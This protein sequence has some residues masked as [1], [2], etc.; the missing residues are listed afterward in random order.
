MSGP[1]AEEIQA[2]YIV[3]QKTE[4]WC[5]NLERLMRRE[6][7]TQSAF[8]KKI[9]ARFFG[10]EER[11]SQKT[12]SNWMNVGRPDRQ[13]HV[14][15]FPKYEIMLQIADVLEVDVEHLT[16]DIECETRSAQNASEYTGLDEDAIKQIR[17]ITLF[18]RE[19]QMGGDPEMPGAI[20]SGI[21]KSPGFPR[22]LEKLGRLASL[23]DRR[24][25]IMSKVEAQYGKEISSKAFEYHDAFVSAGANASEAERDEA[26]DINESVFKS[27][28]IKQSE[29]EAFIKAIA[30]ANEAIDNCFGEEQ[31]LEQAEGAAR[32][33]IQKQ[34]E[35]IVDSLF[36][37]K[38]IR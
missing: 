20:A 25:E 7:L 5:R 14:R 36:P 2:S 32:Y 10:S 23:H 18:E 34:F 13:G 11:F 19:W 16:G 26:D 6:R 37:P 1:N 3:R 8:A 17:S 9:N 38:F 33:A 29:R 30:A 4:K 28:G 21:L 35:Q 22:L 15:P 27:A 24:D 31:S 12:V